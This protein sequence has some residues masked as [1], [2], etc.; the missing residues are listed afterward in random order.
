MSERVVLPVPSPEWWRDRVSLV[1]LLDF[2][3][4]DGEI[5]TAEQARD[6]VEKPWHWQPEYRAL[7]ARQAAE[8]AA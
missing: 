7:L 1:E 5:S 6:V 8:D 2:L 4:E 3:I